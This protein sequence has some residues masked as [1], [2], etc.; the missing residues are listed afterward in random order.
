MHIVRARLSLVS[1]IDAA[2]FTVKERR[3]DVVR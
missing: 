1:K 2:Q 3:V